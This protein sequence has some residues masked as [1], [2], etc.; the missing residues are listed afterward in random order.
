MLILRRRSCT[1]TGST[2]RPV[3]GWT[4]CATAGDIA[5]A[6]GLTVR[7]VTYEAKARGIEPS[8]RK[9]NLG[10]YFRGDQAAILSWLRYPRQGHR[11]PS[12]MLSKG[13]CDTIDRFQ[14]CYDRWDKRLDA[15]LAVLRNAGLR[16]EP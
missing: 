13:A 1:R 9:G 5:D 12:R 3:N 10:L 16:T 6:L 4:G 8:V 11:G 14:K 2:G 7:Q 15:E